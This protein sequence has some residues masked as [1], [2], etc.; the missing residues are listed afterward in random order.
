[1]KSFII[2]QKQGK[3]T[4]NF[5]KN[6]KV[7]HKLDFYEINSMLDLIYSP[8]ISNSMWNIQKPKNSIKFDHFYDKDKTLEVSSFIYLNIKFILKW[9]ETLK[10]TYLR[11]CL[12]VL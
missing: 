11:I 12:T 2:F 7:C 10:Q 6:G 1:M 8:F 4:S 5:K 3:T 9:A